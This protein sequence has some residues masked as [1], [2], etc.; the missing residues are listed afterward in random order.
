MRLDREYGAPT[1]SSAGLESDVD[2][3]LRVTGTNNGEVVRPKNT[4]VPMAEFKKRANA[5]LGRTTGS[6]SAVNEEP[7]VDYSIN[8]RYESVKNEDQAADFQ[9]AMESSAARAKQEARQLASERATE[10]EVVAAD[11]G[12]SDSSYAERPSPAEVYASTFETPTSAAYGGSSSA[13][14]ADLRRGNLSPLPQVVSTIPAAPSG[15]AAAAAPL[16]PAFS[17]SDT[18]NN[19]FGAQPFADMM[20]RLGEPGA[21]PTALPATQADIACPK[22]AELKAKDFSFCLKCGHNF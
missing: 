6:A 19:S 20:T 17:A 18:F 22:C 21:V 3:I 12:N 1:A 14:E 15:S 10:E 4:Q 13:V 5:P 7:A 16:A 11:P 2:R 9:T 8:R